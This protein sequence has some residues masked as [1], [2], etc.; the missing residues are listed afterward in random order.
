MERLHNPAQKG[1]KR[2]IFVAGK[3]LQ[4]LMKIKRKKLEIS[5]ENIVIITVL[6]QYL[7]RIVS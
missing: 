4:K 6:N 7:I 5:L 3:M 1:R 2:G